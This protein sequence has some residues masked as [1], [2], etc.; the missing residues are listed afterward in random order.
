MLTEES[1]HPFKERSSFMRSARSA[2]VPGAVRLAEE[3]W[4]AS[5]IL[6]AEASASLAGV[7]SLLAFGTL[8]HLEHMR[9]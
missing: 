3:E 1:W 9:V 4:G 6:A 2:K 7:L 5:W 8:P